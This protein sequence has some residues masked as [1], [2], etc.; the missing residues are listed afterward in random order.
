VTDAIRTAIE[1]AS[2]YLTEH[3]DEAEAVVEQMFSE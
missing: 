1:G 3:P 2:A